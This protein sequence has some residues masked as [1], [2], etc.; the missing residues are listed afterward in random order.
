M[1]DENNKP[2]V[3]LNGIEEKG[4]LSEEALSNVAGGLV[5]LPS[6]S[7]M[8]ATLTVSILTTHMTTTKS[9]S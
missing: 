5:V 7:E 6:F 4:Q 1:S 2:M 8:L 3:D 9:A